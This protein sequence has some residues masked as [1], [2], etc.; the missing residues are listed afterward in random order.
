MGDAGCRLR[1][2]APIETKNRVPA[3]SQELGEMEP[4]KPGM[5]CDENSQQSLP[6]GGRIND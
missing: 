3:P 6:A 4:D 2:R 1:W 5:S